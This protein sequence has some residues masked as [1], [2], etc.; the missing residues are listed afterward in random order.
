MIWP[1][2][3]P[4]NAIE[5]VWAYIKYR[6]NQYD[7]PPK[8]LIELYARVEYEFKNLDEGFMSL[9]TRA[10]LEEWRL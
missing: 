1:A 9:Y 4:I 7:R 10:C 6:L 2:C 3:S 8:G 5:H